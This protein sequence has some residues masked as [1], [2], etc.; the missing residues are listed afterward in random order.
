MTS[1]QPD[2]TRPGR[3][4]RPVASNRDVFVLVVFAVLG[5]ALFSWAVNQPGVPEA[6]R[7]IV[8]G[9]SAVMVLAVGFASG[10]VRR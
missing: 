4:P 9:F 5:A 8:G 6:V 10:W 2:E 3:A 7:W 1:N